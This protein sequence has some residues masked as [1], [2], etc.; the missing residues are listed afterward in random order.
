[1]HVRNSLGYRL[2]V[3]VLLGA[4]VAWAQPSAEPTRPVVTPGVTAP[5]TGESPNWDEG[6]R[7]VRIVAEYDGRRV[8][9]LSAVSGQGRARSYLSQR[10]DIV[11]VIL[12][13]AGSVLKE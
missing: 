11:V 7:H 9:V 1:M 5:V 13:R 8:K 3:S 6:G 10:S 4:G 2:F 12:D